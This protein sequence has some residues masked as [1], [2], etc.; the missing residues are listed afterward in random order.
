[1]TRETRDQLEGLDQVDLLECREMWDVQGPVE[2]R[3]LKAGKA[4]KEMLDQKDQQAQLDHV[5]ELVLKENLE[6]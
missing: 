4:S 3:V 5:V 6:I 1:M 2:T